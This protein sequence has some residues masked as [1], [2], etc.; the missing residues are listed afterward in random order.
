[1]REVTQC[2]QGPAAEFC[3]EDAARLAARHIPVV[4]GTVTSLVIERDCLQLESS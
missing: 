1:V 2:D 3:A 4:D